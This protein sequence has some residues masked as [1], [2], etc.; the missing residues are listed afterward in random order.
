MVIIL[1]LESPDIQQVS[2]RQESGTERQED[3]LDRTLE[4][5][6]K[7]RIDIIVSMENKKNRLDDVQARQE[8][9]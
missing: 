3:R 7:W 8:K 4:V 2:Q 6:R 1:V 9:S 5:M